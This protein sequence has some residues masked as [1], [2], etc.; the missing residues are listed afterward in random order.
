M[1]N[2]FASNEFFADFIFIDKYSYLHLFYKRAHL[3]FSDFKI[4]LVYLFDF[5]FD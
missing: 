4:P 1:A 3:V 2:F 5:K